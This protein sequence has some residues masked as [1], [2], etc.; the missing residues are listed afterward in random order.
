[1][2]KIKKHTE[3]SIKSYHKDSKLIY[4]PQDS[5]WY[6]GKNSLLLTKAGCVQFLALPM[7]PIQ[8]SILEYEC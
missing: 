2:D 8:D 3:S 6:I 5:Y 7:S 4:K 1:M